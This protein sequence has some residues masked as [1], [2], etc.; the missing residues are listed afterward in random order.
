MGSTH[1]HA[2]THTH[3]HTK[4]NASSYFAIDSEER[5]IVGIILPAVQAVFPVLASQERHWTKEEE[6]CWLQGDMFSSWQRGIQ[7]EPTKKWGLPRAGFSCHSQIS[8]S[9]YRRE[10]TS[11]LVLSGLRHPPF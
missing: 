5:E 8:V 7:T 2:H 1:A 3:T 4:D 6:H 9:S 10:W 11:R